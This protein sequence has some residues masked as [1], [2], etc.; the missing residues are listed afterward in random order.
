[1]NRKM[2][3]YF[4]LKTSIAGILLLFMICL[5]SAPVFALETKI[6][7]G[8]SET[9]DDNIT[10]LESDERWDLITSLFAALSLNHVGRSSVLDLTARVTQQLFSKY[11]E[12][13]S[14]NAQ[15]VSLNYS[16][17]FSRY[18]RITVKDSFDHATDP[19]S[20]EEEFGRRGGRFSYLMNRCG[21]AFVTEIY[22][23]FAVQAR[24]TGEVYY[25]LRESL[26]S[27]YLNG[28]G[29]QFDF[30]WSGYTTTSLMYDFS[31]RDFDPGEEATV[32]TPSALY[33]QYVISQLYFEMRS[34]ADIIEAFNGQRYA[35]PFLIFGIYN[36]INRNSRF[37]V[38]L[39]KQYYPDSYTQDISDNWRISG[40]F[41]QQV[42]RRLLL[43]LNVFYGYG[44]YVATGMT[45]WL[46][47]AMMNIS[48]ELTPAARINCQYS[49][50]KSE[51]HSQY[52]RNAVTLGLTADLL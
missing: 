5:A 30:I 45:Y 21:V 4:M 23:N 52:L 32:H 29:I 39:T 14:N 31:Q 25:P 43:N 38:T 47:G 8:A 49:F 16:S 20:F 41:A 18:S 34:G 17:Q 50:T 44:T 9:Y 22:K 33:R 24:Y 51:G 7:G 46:T 3:K 2:L 42:M 40:T 12:K 36:E 28:A 35:K 26:S 19:K 6:S 27:T 10:F 37:A 13:F 15:S 48:Y 11:F 1:M